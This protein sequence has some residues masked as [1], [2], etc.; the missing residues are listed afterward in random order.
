MGY[1]VITWDYTNDLIIP[2]FR[3]WIVNRKNYSKYAYTGFGCHI[4]PEIALGIIKNVSELI[5]KKVGG[6]V[7]YID[8]TKPGMDVKVVRIII[9][10]DFQ[11]MNFPLISEVILDFKY[12]FRGDQYQDIFSNAQEE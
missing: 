3:I 10:G 7:Y 6:G 4:S 12:Y 2:V 8:L 5:K 11:T 1:D 9:T